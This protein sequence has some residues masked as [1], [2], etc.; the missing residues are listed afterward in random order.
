MTNEETG[1]TQTTHST[2][3][4]TYAF[5]IVPV[6]TYTLR[7]ELAGFKEYVE[8]GIQIHIQNTVTADI[9]LTLGNVAQ[10][11]TVTSDVPLLQ[12]QD[13]SLGQ[14]VPA[15]QVNDLP[16]NGRSWLSLQLL[17][18]GAVT[19]PG[20][21][22]DNPTSGASVN[23]ADQSQTDYRLNGIDDNGEIFGV[24]YTGTF[25]GPTVT[26]IPDAIQE[27]KLQDGDNDAEFGRFNGAVVN[28]VLKSGTNRISGELFEY[29]RN[30]LFNANDYFYNLND[31]A[32]PPYRQNQLRRNTRRSNLYP[33]T[34]QRKGQNVL[35]R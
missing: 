23:G 13:A 14:T 3:I 15:V 16:L 30:Q 4:G 34:I 20:A 28:A 5:A 6:G 17:A 27:F 25:G 32:R 10:Q 24:Q 9:H 11:V 2:S 31:K 8:T 7:A 26:P 35:F 1:I 29:L 19:N 21:S 33:E 18:A 12:A 22:P